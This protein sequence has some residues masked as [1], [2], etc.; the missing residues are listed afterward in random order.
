MS[1]QKSVLVTG[2][3][4]FIGFHLSNKLCKLGYRVVG[5]DNINDYYDVNLKRSRLKIL[6]SHPAFTFHQGDLK[7][8]QTLDLLFEKNK[9]NYVVN[10][11]AQAGVRYSLINPYA[12]MDSNYHGFLNILEA[13]RHSKVE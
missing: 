2:A 3:A 9:F 11:A 1:D 13:C 7:D 6:S 4:G 10:L 12:Y 5:T 8:K